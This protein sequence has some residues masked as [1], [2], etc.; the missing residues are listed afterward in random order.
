M[1]AMVPQ[2]AN[3]GGDAVDHHGDAAALPGPG[4][5]LKGS[6]PPGGPRVL[7]IDDDPD[8][9]HILTIALDRSTLEWNLQLVANADAGIEVLESERPPHLVLLDLNMPGE[10]GW[11]LM[12]RLR[13]DPRWRSLPIVVYTTA[14]HQSFIDRAYDQGANVPGEARYRRRTGRTTHRA[15]P[16]LV[17]CR[18]PAG[19]DLTWTPHRTKTRISVCP[20]WSWT[21]TPM[22]G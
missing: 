17:R 18:P 6:F 19:P 21:M 7:L 10:D 4:R 22:I 13:G 2:S 11:Q 16:V 8:D 20:S 15:R 5:R 1:G 3:D 12:R 9:H 14:Y